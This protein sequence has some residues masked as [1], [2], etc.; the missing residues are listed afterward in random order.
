MIYTL[1]IVPSLQLELKFSNYGSPM[2]DFDG[3]NFNVDGI[4]DRF[5]DRWEECAV[6]DFEIVVA[7]TTTKINA[8][9]FVELVGNGSQIAAK[10]SSVGFSDMKEEAVLDYAGL[11]SLYQVDNSHFSDLRTKSGASDE[12]VNG[13]LEIIDV[14]V[15]ATYEE[16]CRRSLVFGLSLETECTVREFVSPI[17]IASCLL[18]QNVEMYCEKNI[19]GSKANGPVDYVVV[20]RAFAICVTEAKRFQLDEGTIQNVARLKASREA[21]QQQLAVADNIGKKRYREYDQTDYQYDLPS[22]GIVTSG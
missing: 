15:N 22:C 14:Q 3:S 6:S 21:F 19:R 12:V 13:L 11:R 16:L 2:E 4:K 7:K 10:L 20:Y 18:V 1:L 17:L 9:N 5:R 8:T